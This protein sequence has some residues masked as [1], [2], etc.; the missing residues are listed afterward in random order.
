MFN[1]TQPADLAVFGGPPVFDTIRSISNLVRP[2]IEHFLSYSKIFHDARQ[3]TDHGA[4]E[5][6]LERRLAQFHEVEHCVSF[7]GGFWGLVLSMKCLALPGKTEV[8]MPSLT[9]RRLADIVAWAGLVPHFCEVDPATLSITAGTAAP[10]INEN[11]A[12]ILGVH[13]IVNCCDVEGL[14]KLSA[15]T[16]IPLLFDAVESVYESYKGRKIGSCG[17]AE[18]FSMQSSKLFNAF[19][20]GYVTTNDARLAARLRDMRHFGLRDD[21]TLD[22]VGIDAKQ[23]EMHAAMALA[24][25]DD[26]DDQVLR[27]R[28]RYYAYKRLIPTVPDMR[29]VTFDESERCGYK[30]IVVEL[31]PS[32]PVKREHVLAMLQ[33]EHMLP[34]PYYFPALHQKRTDYATVAGDLSATENLAERFLMLPCGHFVDEADIESIVALLRF[35]HAHAA[36][37]NERFPS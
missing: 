23:N 16:G 37:I 14:E 33:A 19:E 36:E 11:T 15:Q 34:R 4:V 20:G 5:R 18:C 30:N 6:E 29:L 12:L 13:P 31:L 25:L 10:C 22:E 3:Y 32:W 24:A 35:I 17:R 8:V 9:Y 27:N 28:D 2:D 1:K 7:A 26:V 21:G